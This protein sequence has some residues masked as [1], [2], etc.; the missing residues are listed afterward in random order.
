MERHEEIQRSLV[1]T[2]RNRIGL[3]LLERLRNMI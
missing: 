2:Y 3:I 1:T